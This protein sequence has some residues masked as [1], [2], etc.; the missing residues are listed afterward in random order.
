[1]LFAKKYNLPFKKKKIIYIR[2]KKTTITIQCTFLKVRIKIP[3]LQ[4][5]S[6]SMD[7]LKMRFN[8]YILAL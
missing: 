3:P 6:L 5:N 2:N 8:K 7:T 1:M 4:I